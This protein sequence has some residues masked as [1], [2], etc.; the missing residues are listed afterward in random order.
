MSWLIDSIG[1]YRYILVY[2]K[3]KSSL[4]IVFFLN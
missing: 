1:M 4:D 2:Q 3:F